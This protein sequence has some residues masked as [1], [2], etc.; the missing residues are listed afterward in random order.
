M[1]TYEE[2]KKALDETMNHFNDELRKLRAGKAS[3]DM[4]K[5]LKV[6]AW[7]SLMPLEQVAS[8]IVTDNTLLTVQPWDKTVIPE[9]A[10]AIQAS[11]LGINPITDAQVVKLPIPPLTTERRQEY[12]KMMWAKAEE[13]KISIRQKRKEYLDNITA[14]KKDGLSEE[15]FDRMQKQMQEYVDSSNKRIDE[16]AKEKEQELMKV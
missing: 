3:P 10:K 8:I 13:G 5:D 11:N 15:E 4:V 1:K 7:G 12:V 14:Q 6:N 9:I 16:L 2:F